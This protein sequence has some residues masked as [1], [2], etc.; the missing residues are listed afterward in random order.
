LGQKTS[1][2]RSPESLGINGEIILSTSY[3]KDAQNT[4]QEENYSFKW[5]DMTGT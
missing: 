4:T 3:P 2:Q 5:T 1:G